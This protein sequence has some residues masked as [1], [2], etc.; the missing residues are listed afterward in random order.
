[1]K[2]TYSWTASKFRTVY[3]YVKIYDPGFMINSRWPFQ[4]S[5]STTLHFKELCVFFFKIAFRLWNLLASAWSVR[6]FQLRLILL[7][8]QSQLKTSKA[9]AHTV[10][11]NWQAEC[12]KNFD[13]LVSFTS[14]NVQFS[15]CLTCENCFA[16]NVPVCM[17]SC[18]ALR[19]DACT[20]AHRC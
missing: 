17:S 11:T 7:D 6:F 20:Y 2:I 14:T 12:K 8:A 1:M 19:P 9:N 5:P 10:K 4:G 3:I 13:S 18:C 16:M 15:N